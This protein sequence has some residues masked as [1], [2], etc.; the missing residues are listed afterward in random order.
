MFIVHSGLVAGVIVLLRFF[1]FHNY[2]VLA[3]ES[4]IMTLLIQHLTR[5]PSAKAILRMNDKTIGP[6]LAVLI[7]YVCVL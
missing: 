6:I 5:D 2:V 1:P 4:V 3:V 7:S